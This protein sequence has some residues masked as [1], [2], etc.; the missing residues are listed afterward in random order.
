MWKLTLAS[1]MKNLNMRHLVWVTF[2]F[3]PGCIVVVL[4]VYGLEA[5]TPNVWWGLVEPVFEGD[6]PFHSFLRLFGRNFR[7]QLVQTADVMRHELK[8]FLVRSKLQSV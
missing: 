4:F 5:L 6:Q 2:W 7:D 1:S 3:L 8:S